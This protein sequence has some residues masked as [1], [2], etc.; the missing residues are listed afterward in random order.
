MCRKREG[1]QIFVFN[2]RVDGVIVYYDRQIVVAEN[3]TKARNQL[4]VAK[5]G[6]RK[7]EE[8]WRLD[9]TE[10]LPNLDDGLNLTAFLLG[11]SSR[12]PKGE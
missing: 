8:K 3:E 2:H 12:L 4:P 7:Q 10:P 11:I 5:K 1:L 9:L 6:A